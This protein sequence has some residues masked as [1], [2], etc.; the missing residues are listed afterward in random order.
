MLVGCGDRQRTLD[1]VMN[2]EPQCVVHAHGPKEWLLNGKRHRL[3]GPALVWPNGDNAWFFNGKMHRIDG[4]AVQLM[5][6]NEWY[7][8]G[9]HL[10]ID[11]DGFWALWERLTPEQQSDCNLLQHAPWLK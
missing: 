9:E 3:D 10:G 6:V 5:G 7:F 2:K 11:D 4:P 8:N 1:E